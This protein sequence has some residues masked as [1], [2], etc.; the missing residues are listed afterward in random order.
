MGNKWR[1]I[2][3]TVSMKYF[4][5]KVLSNE[6]DEG[7]DILVE[8]T[9]Y[10]DKYIVNK[11]LNELIEEKE[12]K[13]ILYKKDFWNDV[14]SIVMIYEEFKIE[15][16]EIKKIDEDH[17]I[18]WYKEDFI[19]ENKKLEE[20]LRAQK[21]LLDLFIDSMPDF[22]FCKDIHG[23]YIN[24][25]KKFAEYIGKSKEDIIGKL[26]SE[27]YDIE[28]AREF[29]YRDN[30]VIESKSRKVYVDEIE[31]LDGTR[32]IEETVKVPYFDGNNHI[33]GVIGATRD[34]SYKKAVEDTLI[35]NE[36]VLFSILNHLDD[37]VIIKDRSKTIFV[38]DAFEKLYGIS[39]NELYKSDEFLVAPNNIHHEDR[40]LFDNINYDEPFDAVGRIIRSDSEVRWVWFRSHPLKDEYNNTLKRII[41]I[42]DI[43][44]KK[45]EQSELDKLREEFFA[46]ISHEFKTPINLIFT[47]LQLLDFKIKNSNIEEK[48]NYIEYIDS[49]N[50]N[51]F[52]MIKL[53]NNLI[54][55]IKIEEGCFRYN[56]A[57][58]DIVSFVE[59][60]CERVIAFGLE[61]SI[62]IIFDTE[63]EEKLAF[64]DKEHMERIILNIL[65]NAIK[66]NSSKG[67]IEV[68][69]CSKNK[70]IEIRIKD[71]GVGISK[72]NLEV[73]FDR[74]K[75]INNRMTKISEG[76]GIGLYIAKS[77]AKM[78]GGNIEIDS[79][80]GIGT[81][82]RVTIPDIENNMDKV[83]ECAMTR[84]VDNV[85]YVQL[86]KMKIE[87]SD[88]YVY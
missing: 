82:V 63:I 12:P 75:M 52:R 66:F 64:F 19:K 13:S 14:I 43:T 81:E 39:C 1:E 47:S 15:G 23:R 6:D 7:F 11:S 74:F 84:R 2:L 77:L 71:N 69:L 31:L 87:F 54:D 21:K 26:D 51:T 28:K 49:C 67:K 4:Y 50:K 70:M 36:R 55:S 88:I 32:Y 48:H 18:L 33:A 83:C 68:Y 30:E 42:N 85:D 46:N 79:V 76:C 56:P 59:N 35:T 60:I 78:H 22:I 27:L 61:N 41:V 65:S 29:R 5:C 58:S 38:N 3:D 8:E 40:H 44:N 16:M 45:E 73:I 25:N 34:I 9:N 53:I 86:D 10:D 17:I 20:E 72:D 37:V 24:C 57:M 80:L 62:D